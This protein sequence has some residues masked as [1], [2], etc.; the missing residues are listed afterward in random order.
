MITKFLELGSADGIEIDDRFTR[1]C[2]IDRAIRRIAKL[3]RIVAAWFAPRRPVV[4]RRREQ[5]FIAAFSF[6]E[7]AERS[8][9]LAGRGVSLGG[10][11]LERVNPA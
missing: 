6:G 4:F 7:R 8:E 9:F 1:I 2:V 11:L 3:F 10:L 5:V